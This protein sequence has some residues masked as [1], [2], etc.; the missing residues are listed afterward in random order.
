MLRQEASDSV[1]IFNSVI[2]PFCSEIVT[3]DKVGIS[4]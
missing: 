3:S 2:S 1:E 4:V